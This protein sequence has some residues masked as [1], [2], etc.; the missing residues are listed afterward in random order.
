RKPPQISYVLENVG[1]VARDHLANERT[2]L[3]YVRTS[4]AIAAMGVAIVQLF[5]IAPSNRAVSHKKYSAR[6]LGATIVIVAVGV[7]GIGMSVYRYFKI[8][9]AM[10]QGIF[11]VARGTIIVI[12]AVLAS[13]AAVI[14]AI[15][16]A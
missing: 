15:L 2:W 8:Q 14:F 13:L 7:L 4:L 5:T 6:P 16:V 3:A 12:T 10:T 9:K 11:P 1:S